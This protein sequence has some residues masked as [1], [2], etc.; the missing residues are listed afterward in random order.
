MLPGSRF[1]ENIKRAES[2][3][4][5]SGDSIASRNALE[6]RGARQTLAGQIRANVRQFPIQTCGREAIYLQAQ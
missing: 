1:A 6:H 2:R 4:F 5:T 3:Y